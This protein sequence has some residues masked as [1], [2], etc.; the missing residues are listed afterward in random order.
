[1]PS[2]SALFRTSVLICALSMPLAAQAETDPQ[3]GLAE[4]FSANRIGTFVAN[5]AIAALRTQMELEYDFLSTDLLRGTVSISGI[6]ARPQLPYDQARQCVITIERAVINTDVA[7]PGEV[8]S[9]INLNL[10]GATASTACVPRDVAMG[11]RAAGMRDITLDQFKLRTAYTYTTGETS[12][13]LTL[14]VNEVAN[15]DF[16]ASGMIL[17][18][19]GTFGPGDP[20]FR[21]MRAVASLKDQGGWA[22][23][24]TVL[25]PNF[26]DPATI[27]AIGAEGVTQFLSNNGTRTVTAVERNFV[28]QLMEKVEEFV[29]DPGELTI[30][31]NL[32]DTGI[33]IEPEVYNAEPQALIASLALEARTSPIARSRILSGAALAALQDPDSLSAADRLA[34]AEALIDGNGVPQVPA[35]VPD[36]VRPLLADAGNAPQAA[37]LVARV[38][39][40]RDAGAAYPFALQAA[41]GGID[42]AVSILDRLEAQMTTVD[43][44]S[45]QGEALGEDAATVSLPD[46]DDPRALRRLSLAYLAGA[47]QTRSYARAYYLAL[48][49]QAA[50]DIAGE[51]L[52]D[53]IDDRFVA[54]GADVADAWAGVS[55]GLQADA[56]ENWIAD[57]LADRYLTR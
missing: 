41:A 52:K 14:S 17:P 24:A 30:E 13:D 12:A 55:A 31:A 38:L 2:L 49:A 5:T 53:E 23:V 46:G 57:G 20:A 10:I 22:K 1:M 35:L 25:P 4:F 6:T 47:G 42:G 15:L 43:V 40:G 18:R 26:S 54:R 56:L 32:P 36:L 11:L 21:V 19:L 48:L 51:T 29:T 34:L 44:L 45:A 3:P 8:A 50:G 9:E 33:V 28:N 39:Q 16:S 37:A 7:K 27:R